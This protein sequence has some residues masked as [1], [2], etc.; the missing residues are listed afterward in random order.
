MR[1]PTKRLPHPRL[2]R[3]AVHPI[4]HRIQAKHHKVKTQL[5]GKH[6]HVEKFFQ[7]RGL[8]LS[9]IRS[10]SAKIIGAGALTASFLL[11]PPSGIKSLPVP[12]EIIEKLRS[13]SQSL[14]D[15]TPKGLLVKSLREILPEK[16][17]P[18]THD[19]EKLLEQIIDRLL[20]IKAKASLEGEHLNT[21]FGLIG[22]EQHLKRYPGDSLAAHGAGKIL[23]AGVAPG[24]GAWGQFA[25]TKA[26]LTPSLEEKERWYAVVQTMYLPDWNRR[27]PYLR[28][29]YRYRKVLI[30]NTQNG[31]TV[32][33][34]IADAGPAA[35]TGKH[36]GGSPE[37]M[38]SLGGPTYKKGP[39][40]LF[41]VDDPQNQIPLGPVD[42]TK[43]AI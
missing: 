23:Q 5:F 34:S 19:E 40:L 35:W 21:T 28:D 11:T 33:A 6:P 29:W 26:E 15:A 24:L 17:R 30:V 9:E 43:G 2:Q 16:V 37:V 31:N 7:D 27:L 1:K 22:A 39:V 10:H 12:Q 36:F 3:T 18:L 14:P 41:F 4:L 8:D 42:Y 13:R 32:V 20:G 25:P 38:F